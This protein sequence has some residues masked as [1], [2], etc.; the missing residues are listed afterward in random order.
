MSR[1][2]AVAILLLGVLTSPPSTLGAV[3]PLE[4][5]RDLPYVK[6]LN[7]TIGACLS[8]DD[9]LKVS[10]V[11]VI[12]GHESEA[13]A[14]RAKHE[15][16][17][18][19]IAIGSEGA[20]TCVGA[21]SQV[22]IWLRG[23]LPEGCYT[24]AG[25]FREANGRPGSVVSVPFSVGPNC[26]AACNQMGDVEVGEAGDTSRYDGD[27]LYAAS[28]SRF[29]LGFPPNAITGGCL[30]SGGADPAGSVG[31]GGCRCT[32]GCCEA[33]SPMSMCEHASFDQWHN[34][35]AVSAAAP[36]EVVSESKSGAPAPMAR[37]HRKRLP[38]CSECLPEV[39]APNR[40]MLPR[41]SVGVPLVR[42]YLDTVKATVLNSA[43]TNFN[44]ADFDSLQVIIQH[45]IRTPISE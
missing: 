38:H 35:T 18:V 9:D 20:E 23:Y 28:S 37:R 12:T 30:K 29:A 27:T 43:Y 5:G 32:E 39:T 17:E 16:S 26:S 2:V 44:E 34:S 10:W 14:F 8:S 15:H 7:P 31:G 42:R 45:A 36:E 33:G 11:L 24:M 22:D 6:F 25:W 21:L 19:C 40:A 13:D 4:S 41:F 3:V 1:I